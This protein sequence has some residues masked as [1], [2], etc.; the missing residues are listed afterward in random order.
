VHQFLRWLCW[1]VT[2]HR[3]LLSEYHSSKLWPAT[4]WRLKTLS[5]F[6]ALNIIVIELNCR[7]G[8]YPWQWYFNKTQHKNAYISK[9]HTTLKQ[10]STQSYR[11]NKGHITHNEHNTQKVEL[12][13]QQTVE[14]YGVVRC[15]GCHIVQTIGSQ[16]VVGL[17]T[18]HAGC[19]L[20]HEIFGYSFLLQAE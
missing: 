11:N 15:Q 18:L 14:A 16:M 1:E 6:S 8:S 4:K 7:W 5:E 20:P 19:A 17:S 9:Y 2:A 12:F 3:R 13:L 10:D